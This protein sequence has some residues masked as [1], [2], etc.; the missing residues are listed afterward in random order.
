MSLAADF[1]WNWNTRE[2]NAAFGYDYILRQCR[3][4]GRIDTD[5]KVSYLCMYAHL[6]IGSPSVLYAS[7][8]RQRAVNSAP[9]CRSLGGVTRLI[10]CLCKL[11]HNDSLM[12]AGA[13]S[14]M[15]QP[16]PPSAGN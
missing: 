5:G 10:K 2:A 8:L 16:V 9:S 6:P 12:T 3:L 13:A 15:P 7:T 4:R 1:L 14:S 11:Q